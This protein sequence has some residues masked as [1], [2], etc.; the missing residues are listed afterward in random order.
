MRRS[1]VLALGLA[2]LLLAPA[3]LA[4]EAPVLVES[5][6]PL[7]AETTRAGSVTFAFSLLNLNARTSFFASVSA[8]GLDGWTL[9][10]APDRFFLEPRAS[11][12]VT[13]ALAPPAQPK[14]T[15]QGRI[16]FSL[17][18]TDTG[19]VT[20]VEHPVTITV[21]DAARVLGLFDNPLPPPLD[22]VYGVFLLDMAFW[23]IVGVA[24]FL[25]GDT[26]VRHLTRFAPNE[27]TR[28]IIRK[29]RW[30]VFWFVLLLGL[31]WSVEVLP[32][33][34]VTVFVDRFLA[35]IAVGIVGLYVAYRVVDAVLFYFSAHVAPRTA[36]RVDDV[37]VPALKKLESVS[38]A[39]KAMTR[40]AMPAAPKSTFGLMPKTL[41]V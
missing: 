24:S 27:V 34:A 22:N 33:N 10:A 11:A 3:A 17:V 21:A 23:A 5:A 41:S 28:T 18:N 19:A 31:R 40:P 36:S 2:A 4:Q 7:R 29:L 8:Q 12:N 38:C 20:T 35:V 32:R 25:T 30:P 6:G 14:E 37:L 26:F 39:A 9:A 16:V 15:V 1:L 13:V